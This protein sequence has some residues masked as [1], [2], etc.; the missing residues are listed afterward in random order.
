MEE[1]MRFVHLAA[2]IALLSGAVAFAAPAS[3]ENSANLGS[4][5][6]MQDQVK[7]ALSSNA[8]SPNYATAVKEQRYGL[9]FCSEGFYRNGVA[10][11]SQALQL[12]G[13]QHS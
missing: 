1:Q 13:A 2:S 6:T 5:A 8:Q 7:A 11:Y 12:L 4:C 9:E 3:A 10:H